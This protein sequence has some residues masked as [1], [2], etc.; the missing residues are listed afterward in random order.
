MVQPPAPPAGPAQWPDDKLDERKAHVPKFQAAGKTADEMIT[1]L[2]AKGAL[3]D[4]QKA[5]VRGWFKPA[6]AEAQ[7]AT[8][9]VSYAA[10]ADRLHK[11]ED[12]DTAVLIVDEGR[13]L[14]A[15]QQ[16][17]LAAIFTSKFQPQG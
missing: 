16:Q 17:D 2:S 1:F 11:C 5:R 6:A 15:D 4:E 9:K 12:R 3:S 10:L 8:I 7:D 14:P 13:A